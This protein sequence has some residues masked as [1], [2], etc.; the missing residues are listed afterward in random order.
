MSGYELAV[1]GLSSQAIT[2]AAQ[3]FI[4]GVVEGQSMDFAPAAP[5]F[6][7]EARNR[8]GYIDLKAKPR[9]PAPT[10]YHHTGSPFHIRQERTRAKYAHLPVLHDN[11]SF[12]QWRKLSSAR[13]VPVGA[14]WVAALAT[15]YGPVSA[16][17]AA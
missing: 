3:R 15:V 2:E 14:I 10:F 13:E 17:T 9:L 12:D 4:G 6:A 1:A 16:K 11:I 7:Q 8:Q 5:R